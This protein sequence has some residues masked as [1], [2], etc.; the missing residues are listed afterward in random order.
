[1]PS[2]RRAAEGAWPAGL[3]LSIFAAENTGRESPGAFKNLGRSR[4]SGEN[5]FLTIRVRLRK[6]RQFATIDARTPTRAPP[7]ET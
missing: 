1:M 7:R 4:L 6:S 2:S 3:I 5:V